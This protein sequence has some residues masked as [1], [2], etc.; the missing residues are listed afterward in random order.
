MLDAAGCDMVSYVVGYRAGFLQ[1]GDVRIFQC[2][3]L[4]PGLTPLGPGLTPL[5]PGLTPLGP[6]LT[7]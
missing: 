3:K 1:Q 6:G 5:G 4:T 2:H 7:S